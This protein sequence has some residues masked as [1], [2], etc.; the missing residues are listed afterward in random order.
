VQKAEGLFKEW[1]AF[2]QGDN[3]PNLE[4]ITWPM[5]TAPFAVLAP[6]MF[7]RVRATEFNNPWATSLLG[8]EW[9][10]EVTAEKFGKYVEACAR[11]AG[12]FRQDFPD[13]AQ[14]LDK[15]REMY[16]LNSWLVWLA[17]IRTDPRLES[18]ILLEEGNHLIF[19]GPPGTGKTYAAERL[20]ARMAGSNSQEASVWSL[21]KFESMID[22]KDT[23]PA[24]KVVKHLV[25]FHASY[26]Y[27]DFVRGFR[28]VS[29]E[30]GQMQFELRDGPF[31]RIVGRALDHPDIKFLLVIDEINR[32][33]LARVLGECFYLLDR[34]VPHEHLED[35][36]AG[37]HPGAATL[38][39]TG[40]R[41]GRNDGKAPEIRPQLAI[42]ENFFLVG[43]MNTADRSTAIVDMALRRRFKFVDFRPDWKVV[44]TEMSDLAKQETE[45]FEILRHIFE[46]LNG[47][48][49]Q[50]NDGWI[51]ESRYRIGHSYF[52]ATKSRREKY[53]VRAQMREITTKLKYQLLPL[54][55]EYE[56]EGK[57]QS[58]D[59][60][61]CASWLRHKIGQ[62]DTLD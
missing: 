62:L 5:A 22:E 41:D 21:D 29:G 53:R 14:G 35:A 38:R 52:M 13:K 8:V 54:L 3:S 56:A 46:T 6:A 25:Q 1:L 31:A 24:C 15:D 58:P 49:E 4:K 23:V 42:P 34:Q 20:A 37:H 26:D 59:E 30:D 55:V 50:S 44:D 36:F 39:Y 19:Q 47:A 9:D 10:S 61:D 16:L 43:T 33:D 28:P 17:E 32:A 7:P 48:K 12:T 18:L 2:L 45:Q 40:E 51:T 60:Q 27:E 11:L 57:V